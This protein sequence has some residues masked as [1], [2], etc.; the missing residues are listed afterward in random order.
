MHEK[1]ANIRVMT[2]IFFVVMVAQ[3]KNIVWAFPCFQRVLLVA[4]ERPLPLFLC[5]PLN[6]DAAL[7]DPE[8]KEAGVKE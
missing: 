4:T 3:S 8:K 1:N 6:E 7:H 2:L 5:L